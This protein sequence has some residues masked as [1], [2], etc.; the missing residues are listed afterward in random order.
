MILIQ[1]TPGDVVQF[2]SRGLVGTNR[3]GPLLDVEIEVPGPVG[4]AT[5]LAAE[6]VFIVEDDG[7]I[8]TDGGLV[9]SGAEPVRRGSN[10]LR[11]RWAKESGLRYRLA[12]R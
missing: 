2:A 6:D 5:I 10:G 4:A 12:A 7:A 8:A 11:G 1:R 9:V 3:N